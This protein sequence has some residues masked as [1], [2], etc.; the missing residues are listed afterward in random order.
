MRRRRGS[1]SAFLGSQHAAGCGG[2][3]ASRRTIG[4]GRAGEKRKG[5][6]NDQRGI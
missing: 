6:L 4:G 2:D 5:G 3:G 1:S